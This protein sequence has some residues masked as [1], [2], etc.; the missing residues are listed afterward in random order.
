MNIEKTIHDL[1]G[2]EID[3]QL[4]QKE[5]G[6]PK[7]GPG[8]YWRFRHGGYLYGCFRFSGHGENPHKYCI[9]PGINIGLIDQRDVEQNGIYYLITNRID[10]PYGEIQIISIEELFTYYFFTDENKI[11]NHRFM[12]GEKIYKVESSAK[13]AATELLQEKI[14]ELEDSHEK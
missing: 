8:C 3:I 14:E 5:N 13:A 2:D 6:Q 7:C 10:K 1:N 11:L 4:I 9:A 12:G